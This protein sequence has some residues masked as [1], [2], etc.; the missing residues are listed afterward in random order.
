[1]CLI[2]Y[3][4]VYLGAPGR[5]QTD[6]KY[7]YLLLFCSGS[8]LMAGSPA[9][10][11]EAL[12]GKSF[13]AEVKIKSAALVAAKGNLP[14]H[15]DVRGVIAP[16]AGFAIKLPTEWNDRFEM[17]GNGG[18][19]GT[20]SL[21]AVDGAVRKGFASAS[22]D[23]GHDA[24]K[25]P[26]A[27]FAYVTQ[28]NPNG[29]RKMIDFAYLSVH[30]T[31]VLAKQ[32]IN[33]YYGA[34]PKYSY[35][36]GCS[37]GG[38]QGLHE[39]QRYPEDFDGLVVG[40]PGVYLTGNVT[41]RL[42]IGQAQT[43]DGA[44]TADQLP[45]LTKAIYEKCDA[46]DGLK[47]GLIDDP[48]V[49]QF[50]PA[51]DLPAGAFT[52]AQVGALKKI[53]GGPKNSKGKQVFYGELVG[54]E[55]V[56]PDNF[57]PPSKT[58]LPRSESQ[59]K[60]M[61][62]DPPPGPTWDYTKFNFDTDPERLSKAAADLN[63]RNPDLAPLKK[64][65]GKILQYAGWGDQQ[66]NPLP[67]IEYYET[68]SKK[69]GDAATRD[70]YRLYMIPGMFHCSGGPGCGSN[71]WLGA[72]MD[73]VEKGKAPDQMVGA[74]V[75]GG[76]TTRTRPLCAYPLVARYKGMGSVDE[77]GSFSCASAATR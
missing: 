55:P 70:F 72:V 61:M 57:I 17:V 52:A 8:M 11:C 66:V 51:R 67:G 48:R 29:H 69:L 60:M 12:A 19:A 34:A 16:E 65:G 21:S 36:V 41:R 25:E 1:M 49:C 7:A 14:E 23:T 33:A 38:R 15:C 35:W 6:F 71:D 27:T 46:L 9:M 59:A 22:T 39:A 4:L 13:G 56:W 37:T 54:S 28:E 75:E 26:L 31:A 2:I 63:P 76:A 40:A 32:V 58:V 24:E 18:T 74:H 43:G 47:D 45:I 53:Y 20:I 3:P 10:K 5:A 68:V 42:W 50:D 62:L 44:I 73:W 64:R 77:A 30:E